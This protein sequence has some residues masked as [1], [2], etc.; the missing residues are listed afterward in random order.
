MK[1]TIAITFVLVLAGTAMASAGEPLLCSRAFTP[2]AQML[3]ITCAGHE[4]APTAQPEQQTIEPTE[5]GGSIFLGP[6]E[7]Q[8]HVRARKDPHVSSGGGGQ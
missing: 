7:E 3:N 5:E 1:K 2:L 4:P 6:P 8:P